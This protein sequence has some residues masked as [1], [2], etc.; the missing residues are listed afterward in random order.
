M[1][2]RLRPAADWAACSTPKAYTNLADGNHTFEVRATDPAGNTDPTPA[3]RSFTIDSGAPDTQIDSG[4]TGTTSN[5]SPSFGFS[6]DEPGSSF[7]CRLDSA[8]AADWAACSTPKAYTNLAD[9]NHTFEVRATDPAGNTDPTPASRSF[10]IDSGAPD[11]QIDSGPT[12]TTSNSSPSFGF[13]ADEPGSS[14][15]CRLDSASAADWAACSTPKA[16]TNLADG[17]HTF[18]VRA[19]DPAGNTD[20]T[21]ASRSFT[22]DSG[23]PDTQIDSGPTGTT[24]NSSPSFGFSADEPGSSFECRLDSASAA[25]WAACSTPRPTPTWPTA[26]TPSRSERPIGRQHRPDPGLPQLHDRLRR[27]RH[28]DRLRAHRDDLQLEPQLRLLGR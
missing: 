10:T 23:A 12:G 27:P 14:F 21:P 8:S 6:A 19:T 24:S 4:P 17:N 13:S 11:T 7:E 1:S 26:T 9:G 2:P 16:Y 25:D 5:S 18:E 20:P 15:E 3:S 28:P 22:I